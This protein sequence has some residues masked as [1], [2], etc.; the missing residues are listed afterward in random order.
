MTK[1]FTHYF[2]DLNNRVYLENP[3]QFFLT[4]KKDSISYTSTRTSMPDLSSGTLKLFKPIPDF[5]QESNIT[6]HGVGYDEY[7]LMTFG[8]SMS[9]IGKSKDPICFNWVIVFRGNNKPNTYNLMGECE[10]AK[11]PK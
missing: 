2:P 4:I 9:N 10:K 7:S 6:P 8:G 3:M 11:F 5:M 1:R